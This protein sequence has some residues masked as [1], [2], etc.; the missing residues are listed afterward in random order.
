MSRL[1]RHGQL[2]SASR[3]PRDGQALLG[4][5]GSG[6]TFFLSSLSSFNIAVFRHLEKLPFAHATR[7]SSTESI[8]NYYSQAPSLTRLIS[9][10][11]HQTRRAQTLNSPRICAKMTKLFLK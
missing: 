7:A 9:T 1:E 6:I 2:S 3:A 5:T 10:E 11:Q 8:T 4:K